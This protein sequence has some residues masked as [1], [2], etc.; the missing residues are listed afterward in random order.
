MEFWGEHGKSESPVT[1]WQCIQE[2]IILFILNNQIDDHLEEV[3][4]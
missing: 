3:Q 4:L 1:P 2:T